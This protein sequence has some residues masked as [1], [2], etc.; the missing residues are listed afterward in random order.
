MSLWMPLLPA[1]VSLIRL[2]AGYIRN[3]E[4]AV[5]NTLSATSLVNNYSYIP[6]T[7]P[8]YFY[9]NV[10]PSG[11]TLMLSP[12]VDCLLAVAGGTSAY[13]VAGGTVAGVWTGPPET[14]TIA[15]MPAHNHTIP[16]NIFLNSSLSPGVT[17]VAINSGGLTGMTGGGLSHQHDWTTTRPQ[18]AVGIFCIKTT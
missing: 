15:Q 2:S 3:N 18:A 4:M 1:D 6:F 8:V 7:A 14:L 9:T 16:V 11:W 5:Q 17:A 12:P 10:I 13:N